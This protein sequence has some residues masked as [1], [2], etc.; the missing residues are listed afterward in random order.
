MSVLREALELGLGALALTCE[1][2]G[3]LLSGDDE[4]ATRSERSED[5]RAKGRRLAEELTASIRAEV[6]RAGSRGGWVRREELEA[7]AARV[8]ELEAKLAQA[9]LAARGAEAASDL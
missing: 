1:T 7:L 3:E 4:P 5:L 2:A 6:D 9:E 8:A